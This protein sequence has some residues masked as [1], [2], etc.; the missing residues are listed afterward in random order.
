MNNGP[1]FINVSNHPFSEWQADQLHAAQRVGM[2][3]DILFPVIPSEWDT[4]EVAMLVDVYR[5]KIK[6]LLPK[7][8]GVSVVHVMG[9]SVFTFMLVSLLLSEKYIVVAST[10]ERVVSYEEDKKISSF[11]FVRFRKYHIDKSMPL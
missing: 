10:T 9:E 4:Q 1:V 3:C 2:V 5:K 7:P 8:D 11:K 6:A